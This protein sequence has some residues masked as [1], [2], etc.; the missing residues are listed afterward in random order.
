MKLPSSIQIE[1]VG[2]CNLRCEM[3]PIQFRHD[4]PPYGPLAFMAWETFVSLL[5]G[6]PE[7]KRLHLQGLGEPMMHPRFFEMVRHA[8]DRGIEVTTNSN[9][10]LLNAARA[11]RL[12]ES[13][14]R[15]LF[16]S[17][18]GS[19][20]ETYERIRKRAR[21]DRVVANIEGMLEARRRLGSATP[22]LQIVMVIMRQNLHE[23]PALVQMAHAWSADGM[24]V[25]HLSHDFGEPTLPEAYRPMRDYIAAQSLAHED[26]ARIEKYFGEARQMAESVGLE[27]RLPRTTPKRYPEGTAG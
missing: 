24:F 25:Q 14:L 12:V 1:P 18:D 22:G 9:L 13:G 4:G 10:T 5:D 7:L 27:L 23:L 17:I 8:A 2:Q 3:C 20:P 21:F 26:P 15:T 16:F 6:F 19:T 11:E